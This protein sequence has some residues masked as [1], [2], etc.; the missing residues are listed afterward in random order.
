MKHD[1]VKEEEGVSVCER[2]G[3]VWGE[4]PYQKCP[5]KLSKRYRK[6]KR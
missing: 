4:K 3:Y 1:F 2:C 6:R 5:M